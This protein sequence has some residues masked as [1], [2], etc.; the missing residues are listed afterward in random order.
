MTIKVG[1]NWFWPYR[2]RSFSVWLLSRADIQVGGINDL[3]DVDYMACM[4]EI[5]THSR[6]LHGHC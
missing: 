5:T 1:I 4:L 3:I 6:S 2:G